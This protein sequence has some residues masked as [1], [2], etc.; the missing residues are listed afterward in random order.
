MK[1]ACGDGKGVEVVGEVKVR[2]LEVEACWGG[3]WKTWK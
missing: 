3:S 2:F 1:A